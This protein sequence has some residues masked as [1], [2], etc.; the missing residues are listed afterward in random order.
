MV[1]TAIEHKCVLNSA[2]SL[3]KWGFTVEVVPVDRWGRVDPSALRAALRDDTALV[4]V[5]MANNEVGTVHADRG[6]RR[7]VPGTGY[8]LSY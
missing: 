1:T 7:T 3:R 8:R 2:L 4:S 5:M 6:D